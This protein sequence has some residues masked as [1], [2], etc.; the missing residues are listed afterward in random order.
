MFTKEYNWLRNTSNWRNISTKTNAH[1]SSRIDKSHQ[2]WVA[3]AL[4]KGGKE[5]TLFYAVVESIKWY[6]ISRRQFGN[7][8][9]LSKDSINSDSAISLLE[10]NSKIKSGYNCSS[11]LFLINFTLV[12][13][14][15][16][17]TK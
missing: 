15:L 5:G 4:D 8:Y 6:N 1:L 17:T 13:N 16:V 3:A 7:I 14:K 10:V 9:K 11:M 2:A 12:S